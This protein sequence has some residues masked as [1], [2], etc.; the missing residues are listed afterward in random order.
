MLRAVAAAGVFGVGREIVYEL[1]LLVEL[2]FVCQS[3][4]EE[5]AWVVE[6]RWMDGLP[7]LD[8]FG[9]SFQMYIHLV[10]SYEKRRKNS[11]DGLLFKCDHPEMVFSF[12]TQLSVCVCV[13]V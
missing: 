5:R 6:L 13:S 7:W 11:S 3:R 1:C 2:P 4:K 9:Q 8:S 10:E 12:P